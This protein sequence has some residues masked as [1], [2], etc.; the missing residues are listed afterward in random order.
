MRTDMI[1]VEG[2][3]HIA[4]TSKDP[5][6]SIAF[7]KDI[8]GLKPVYEWPGEVTMLQA[9]ETYLAIAWWNK[10]K[11]WQELPAITIDHF[12]FRLNKKNF[13]LAEEEIKR[14]GIPFDHTSDHGVSQS[15]YIRD[16]DHHLL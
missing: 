13:E 16:P 15:F 12:A 3:D 9:G 11:S 7:Y 6:K 4:I 8:F 1:K 14:R 5:E 10:G 2:L